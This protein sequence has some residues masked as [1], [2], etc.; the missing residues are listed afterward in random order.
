LLSIKEK[1]ET[2]L[3]CVRELCLLHQLVQPALIKAPC[4]FG[5]KSSSSPLPAVFL[6]DL[7]TRPAAVFCRCNLFEVEAKTDKGTMSTSP[8][9]A[10][11][12][13]RRVPFLALDL[14]QLQ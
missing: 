14:F 6:L 7:D 10:I 4:A 3:P 12:T 2:D 13:M 9:F 1:R 11:V 8:P 5:G